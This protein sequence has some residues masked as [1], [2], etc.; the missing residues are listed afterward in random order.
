MA[1]KDKKN[2]KGAKKKVLSGM[3]LIEM[4]IAIAIIGIG[5]EGFTLLF[6]NTWRNNSYTLEMGQSSLAVSQGLNKIVNY[7]RGTRQA[8]NGA[9]PIKSANDNDLVLYSD[10]NKDGIT[11]RLH[12][13][14]NGQ[15][16]LMGITDPSGT[17]P[18]SYQSSD[19]Q[20]AT[21][22]SHIVNTASEPI[23]YYFDKDF[24]GDESANPPLS[25]PANISDIRI[26]KIHL[27]ININPNRAPDNIEM[28]S[29]VEMRNLNDYDRLQ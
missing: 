10:Y 20:V 9:Y 16:V 29:F 3:T 6:S 4:M 1:I 23:F 21:I 27:K 14:K 28:Q 7:I 25:T 2:R 12:F 18:V 11:E 24:G 17:I 22:A 26:V 13:Y 8:D 19:Q 15:N 5:M